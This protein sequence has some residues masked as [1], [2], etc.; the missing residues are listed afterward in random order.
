MWNCEQSVVFRG[1][2]VNWIGYVMACYA[3]TDVILSFVVGA[4]LSSQ[5]SHTPAVVF[6][7]RFLFY[8]WQSVTVTNN[9]ELKKSSLEVAPTTLQ[10]VLLIYSF[11]FRSVFPARFHCQPRKEHFLPTWPWTLIYDLDLY[12]LNI[13]RVSVIHLVKWLGQRL[14]YST[15]IIRECTQAYTQRTDCNTW[16]TVRGQ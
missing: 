16:T 6:L 9:S 10:L 3:V 11:Q 12:E 1:L 2:G 8:L 15:V 13:N 7:G 5:P 14:F 4:Y